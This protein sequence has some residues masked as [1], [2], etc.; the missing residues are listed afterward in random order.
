MVL[1]KVKSVRGIMVCNSGLLEISFFL[2]C[3]DI[4]IAK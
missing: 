3:D 1:Q 2:V 4:W